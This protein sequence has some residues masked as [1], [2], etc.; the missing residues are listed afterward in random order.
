ERGK[1]D[2]AGGGAPH[3]LGAS[4]VRNPLEAEQDPE[5]KSK[6]SVLHGGGMKSLK[7]T[8]FVALSTN[9][10]NVIGSTT[11]SAIHPITIAQKSAH[12]VS[13]GSIRMHARTRVATRY[14]KGSTA[15]ASMA[16]ICS[17]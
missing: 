13:R 16:S 17:E 4:G 7:R 5:N 10:R 11:V 1:H 2:R 15:E 12:N 14:R 3:A 6:T 8:P 9:R